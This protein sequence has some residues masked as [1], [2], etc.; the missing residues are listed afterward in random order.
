MKLC[1]YCK[2][3]IEEN[4]HYCRNC[5]KPL[6]SNLKDEL[7]RSL[8]H[9]Y[10]E[11]EFFHP[12]LDD[13]E[14]IY[15]GTVIKDEEIDQKIQKI[16]ET[17]ES[18]ELLGES[19]PGSLLLEKSSLY[20]K[21]RDLSNA[22]KNLEMALKNF[23]EEDDLTN[24]AICHNEMGLIQE[25]TG[26]FDQSIYHFN[27][28]L[29]ILKELNDQEK[30]IKVLNNLGNIYYILKDLEHSYSYYEEA[31]KTAKQEN[32]PYEEIK[33][34]NNLIEILYLLKEYKRIEK[35]LGRNSEFFR[36]HEDSYGIIQ[37]HIKYGK[38]Y[39]IIGEDY[40]LAY[41]HLNNALELIDRIKGNISVYIKARLEW[42][43]Y[44]FLGKIYLLWDNTAKAE[45]LLLQSLEAV[46][47]FEIGDNINEGEILENLAEIYVS[48]G[49]IERA[50]EYYNLSSEIFYKFGDA[51]KNAELK[52]K[53]GKIYL[54]Y[55]EN[56][57]KAMDVLEEALKIYEDLGYTKE[58]AVL[59]H[60][61]G[62]IYLH[63]GVIDIAI[64]NFERARDYYKE[65]HDD[66]SASLLDE[67]IRSLTN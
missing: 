54:E 44:L 13:E 15:E 21:K 59:L 10:D 50:I 1:P 20:Y 43:C 52:F 62:D 53:I 30:I 47:I 2:S 17:L 24:I 49:D 42:E 35:I 64:E 23:K 40:D 63:R 51:N 25:D 26:F 29:E 16:E 19:I 38:L 6:I 11:I 27:R 4:W 31:L 3:P 12:D 57:S 37:T 18:K 34:S 61:L 55:E 9:S 33:T 7:N 66:Y 32:L 36:E 60:K 65:L 46:R 28:S 48:K 56:Q 14:E 45:N 5:N 58:S 67:K 39:Y 8:R 41:Q 22:L